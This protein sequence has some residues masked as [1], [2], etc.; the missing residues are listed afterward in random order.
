M[1]NVTG[2]VADYQ[3][4]PLGDC[5][6][7]ANGS[8]TSLAS[9]INAGS[10]YATNAGLYH[11]TTTTN[12]VKETNSVVDI[13]FHLVALNPQ[14]STLNLVDTDGDTFAD[15]AE[16][17][18]GDGVFDAGTAETDWKIYNSPMGIGTNGPGL[19][20]FTPLK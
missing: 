12:Q 6:Y 13:G 11:Y 3:T 16:D 4:G 20:L 19:V 14:L 10:Q 18:D 7:P 9:L 8:L 15:V 2:I 1:G 17:L 5:Y